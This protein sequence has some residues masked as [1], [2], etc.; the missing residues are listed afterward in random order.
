MRTERRRGAHTQGLVTVRRTSAIGMGEVRDTVL[1]R[2]EN[3]ETA[4]LGFGL[5][6]RSSNPL[7]VK[8]QVVGSVQRGKAFRASE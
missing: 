2:W 4:G 6:I 5:V 3:S 7:Y 8:V 1:S